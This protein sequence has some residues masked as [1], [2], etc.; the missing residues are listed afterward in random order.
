MSK[1]VGWLCRMIGRMSEAIGW[2]KRLDE[3]GSL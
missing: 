2:M 1:E 3:W